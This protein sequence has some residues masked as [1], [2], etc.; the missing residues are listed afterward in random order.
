[1]S[2]IILASK[3]KIRLEILEKNRIYCVSQPANIDE[4]DIKHSMIK[5]GASPEDVSISLAELK[6]NK[7]SAKKNDEIMRRITI[8]FHLHLRVSSEWT[9][10]E[11]LHSYGLGDG[12]C[13]ER[14]ATGDKFKRSTEAAV[15]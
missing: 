12:C 13:H 7:V 2:E 4:D 6:A 14:R 9:N 10:D 1:M 5:Q 11:N 15:A 3:S 8:K